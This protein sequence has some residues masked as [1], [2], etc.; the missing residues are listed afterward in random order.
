MQ[1]RVVLADTGP[2]LALADE[3][4][5]Y[6][7]RANEEFARLEA[8]GREFLFA[9]PIVM[10]TYGV[11]RRHLYAS[12]AL[13]W[14]KVVIEDGSVINPKDADYREAFELLSRFDDQDISLFDA[15]LAILSQRLEVAVWTFD[16]DFDV[17]GAAVWR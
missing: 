17:L 6:H 2:L 16:G 11:M 10:E 14:L 1:P 9:Y 15:T 13:Q 3:S 4:D 5:Q 12:V 8:E 7:S